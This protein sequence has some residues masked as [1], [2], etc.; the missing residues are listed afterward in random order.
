VKPPNGVVEQAHFRTKTAVEQTL[1]LRGSRGFGDEGAFVAFVRDVIERKR[2]A[3]AAR[4]LVDERAH[5]RSL[6]LAPIPSYTTFTCQVRRWSTIYLGG[7]T[8][9]VPARLIGHTVEARRHPRV[10][11]VRYRGEVLETMPRLRRRDHRIDYRRII[12]ALVRKPGAFAR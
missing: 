9:S 11:E 7:R 12:G 2:N 3:A 1:R 8:Y 4:R 6:P 5:L 10:V